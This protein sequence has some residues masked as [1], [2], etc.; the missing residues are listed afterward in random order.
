[1][2]CSYLFYPSLFPSQVNVISTKKTTRIPPFTQCQCCKL[3]LVLCQNRAHSFVLRCW[4]DILRD[5]QK[6]SQHECWMFLSLIFC[7]SLMLISSRSRSFLNYTAS[8]TY[9]CLLT[10][11]N[12][13]NRCFHSPYFRDFDLKVFV[14][15]DI[16]SDLCRGVLLGWY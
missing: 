2:P 7:S 5:E 4:R 8:L 3:L 9:E 12:W 6:S 14:F 13:H 1:M 10:N 11:N 16:F 15:R